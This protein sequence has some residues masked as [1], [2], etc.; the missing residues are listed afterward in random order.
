MRALFKVCLRLPLAGCTR[1]REKLI[2]PGWC[3]TG[4]PWNAIVHLGPVGFPELVGAAPN[5]DPS[6]DLE[7]IQVLDLRTYSI[8][9]STSSRL[10]ATCSCPCCTFDS[11]VTLCCRRFDTLARPTMQSTRD[12]RSHAPFHR[13]ERGLLRASMEEHL[14]RHQRHLA[15][16]VQSLSTGMLAR[17]GSAS[18]E[19]LL[20]DS[21]SFGPP[22]E[23]SAVVATVDQPPQDA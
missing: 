15:D 18:A 11:R 23:A 1:R 9:I 4:R 22:A 13:R 3:R 2:V 17:T 10:L 7:T 8:A 20:L 12:H 5:E 14:Q 21:T 16:D 6:R 19:L